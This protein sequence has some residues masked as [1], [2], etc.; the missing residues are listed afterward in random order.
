MTET[1][2]QP[3]D[4]RVLFPTLAPGT[5]VHA[6]R[7]R[8]KQV[9]LNLLSN[10]V[11][12]NRDAG[13]VVVDC[14]RTAPD[15]LRISVQD[16]GIGM[17]PEQQ[18]ALFQPFNR[19]G[20]EASGSEGTGI[21]LV[22][23][24]RLVDLM[25]GELGFNSTRG[26]GSVFWIDLRAL[27]AAEADAAFAATTGTMP[28]D[29]AAGEDEQAS[30]TTVLCVEDNPASLDLIRAAMAARP[31][32]RLLT[33]RNGQRGVELART[34]LPD[35]ILMDNNMPVLSGAA[36]QAILRSD[37][38]TTHIPIIAI[39]ANAM[40]NAVATGLE[41]GFFRYLTKPVDL[42]ALAEALDSALAEAARR[43]PG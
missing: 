22:V 25:G 37:P 3:R 19:L 13:S 5:L 40:P 27:P 21:G 38:R 12:Y 41:A 33:A 1:L 15:R 36:A 31:G 11:K 34:H 20:Q 39:S 30:V 6:D 42:G 7:T 43:K 26:V 4:I 9:L 24:R 8:L 23:T 17:T 18:R 29:A 2:A 32:V 16:T 14:T 10:A 35:V 28:L